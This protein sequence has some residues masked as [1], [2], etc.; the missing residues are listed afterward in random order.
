MGKKKVHHR[1]DKILPLHLLKKLLK[2]IR[3]FIWLCQALVVAHGL[4]L[5]HADLAGARPL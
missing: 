3:L 1:C 4:S 2:K 5:D